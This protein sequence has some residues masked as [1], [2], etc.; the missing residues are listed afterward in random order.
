ME[1]FNNLTIRIPKT[2]SEGI[3]FERTAKNKQIN[4]ELHNY[5]NIVF[6]TQKVILK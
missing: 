1:Y 3:I 5:I 4:T 2:N 6:N